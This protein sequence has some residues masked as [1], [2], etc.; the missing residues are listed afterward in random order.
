MTMRALRLASAQL[1]LA[2]VGAAQYRLDFVLDGAIELLWV[3]TAI[4]PLW[5]VFGDHGPIAGWSWSRAL[6]VVG[7]FTTLQAIVE[8][9]LNPSLVAFAESVRRGT[10]DAVLLKPVDAQLWVA[11]SHLQP[12]RASS[13]ASGLAMI[14]TGAHASSPSI[15][16]SSIG[17]A[18]ALFSSSIVLL[19]AIWTIAMAASVSIFGLEGLSD[20][21]L[22]I[23]DGARWPSS[24]YRGAVRV[25]L[26]FVVPLGV[27]TTVPAQALFGALSAK[28]A[29]AAIVEALAFAIVARAS[30]R[31]AIARYAS[32]GG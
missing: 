30:F 8:G 3:A 2:F 31:R 17:L 6:V 28:H 29:I 5:V 27:L 23:L 18:I 21:L 9:A 15:S 20:V 22:A 16:A 1:R 26:T 12:W 32:A 19:S 7:F 14:A 13:A 10:L 25:A 11:T 24:I 4:V